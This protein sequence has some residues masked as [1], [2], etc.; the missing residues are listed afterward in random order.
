MIVSGTN[1]VE[2][3]RVT[4]RMMGIDP[5]ELALTKEAEK[6]GFGDPETEIVGTER[7]VPFRRAE[8]SF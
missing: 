3:D 8:S 6:R 1:S 7:V 4:T 2:V 5:N